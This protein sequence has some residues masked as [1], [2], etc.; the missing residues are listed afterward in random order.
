[1]KI[2]L[3]FLVIASLILSCNVNCNN[4]NGNAETKQANHK[5]LSHETI[6]I[7]KGEKYVSLGKYFKK[8]SIYFNK[9]II[10]EEDDYKEDSTIYIAGENI[11]IEGKGKVR[12]L[13]LS[14]SADIMHIVGDKI[15]LKNLDFQHYISQY[16]ECYG[17][18]IEFSS[19]NIE[20]SSAKNIVIENCDINGCGI[21]GLKTSGNDNENIVVKN[22]LIHNCSKSAYSLNDNYNNEPENSNIFKFENTI[23]RNNGENRRLEINDKS[24][25]KVKKEEYGKI[26]RDLPKGNL[27]ILTMSNLTCTKALFMAQM[28]LNP[29]SLKKYRYALV[30]NK[31]SKAEYIGQQWFKESFG[32]DGDFVSKIQARFNVLNGYVFKLNV[33]EPFK[34]E[35]VLLLTKSDADRISFIDFESVEPYIKKKNEYSDIIAKIE[36]K[37][38]KKV[39]V[40]VGDHS[41]INIIA[42]SK[43]NKILIYDGV[44]LSESEND[45]EWSYFIALQNGEDIFIW[46]RKDN[47]EFIDK[48]FSVKDGDWMVYSNAVVSSLFKVGDKYSLV[49]QNI[50]NMDG[51]VEYS[52]SIYLQESNGELKVVNEALRTLSD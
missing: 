20:F 41:P 9:T 1:M 31:I 38:G 13:C 29:Q 35:D 10:I 50:S 23:M 47:W 28:G 37:K 6:K 27:P 3:L 2:N 51:D 7:G 4:K 16:D 49:I 21:V 33:E 48:D 34:T 44:L 39:S 12:I 14:N 22:S 26:I 25:T 45:K 17:S 8:D 42:K 19:E 46:E 15:T 32:Y 36:K 43:D 18:V 40:G 30:E 24:V 5:D 52:L 11:T